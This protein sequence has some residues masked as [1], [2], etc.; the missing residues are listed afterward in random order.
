MEKEFYLASFPRSG[1]T[2]V[3]FLIANV[4]NGMT[5]EFPQVDF[6]NIH[7]IVPE[8]KKDKASKRT[9]G[10]APYFNEF[11][12][13]IKTHA[14]YLDSFFNVILL[15]R[16]PFDCLY[17]YWDYLNHNNNIQISLHETIR[18]PRYGISAVVQHANSYVRHCPHLL[19]MTFEDLLSCPERQLQKLLD[20]MNFEVSNRIVKSAI[21][22]SSFQTMSGIERRKGRKYGR[23][24]FK[25]MRKG[26][27]GEGETA[28]RQDRE[29]NLY[30]LGEM[31][32]SPILYLLYG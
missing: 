1:N 3:R 27:A 24:D 5:K 12:L 7:E 25:F 20:F 8:L 21:Q 19:V 23:P 31:K 32:K 13:V 15:I 18:H 9:P 17:S 26:T 29:L 10:I 4:Y 28:I 30:V 14:N 2:W 22:A 16:N 6:F 11:P